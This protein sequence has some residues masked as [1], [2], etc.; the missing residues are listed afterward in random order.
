MVEL[1]K[2]L[3][4]VVGLLGRDAD[5]RILYDKAY[6]TIV[7]LDRQRSLLFLLH[8]DARFSAKS[9]LNLSLQ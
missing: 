7:D 9:I 1:Y 8:K 5:S 6:V 3:E 4:D 2:L